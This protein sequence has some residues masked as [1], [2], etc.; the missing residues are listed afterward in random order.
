MSSKI[1]LWAVISVIAATV[2][3]HAL[4]TTVYRSVFESAQDPTTVVVRSS[5]DKIRA[6]VLWP[7]LRQY[8]TA[9]GD[10]LEKSG[11]ERIM[12]TGTLDRVDQQRIAVTAILE[13]PDRLQL[14]T[15]S[16]AQARTISYDGQ[17]A[18]VSDS[19]FTSAD[20]DLIES[21]VSDSAEHFFKAQAQGAPTRHL[22]DRFRADDGS[23]QNYAGPYHD[24]FSLFDRV[25]I[26]SISRSQTKLYYF[27]SDTHLLEKVTYQIS[28]NGQTVDV[29]N[30]FSDWQ[31]AQDQQVFRR[32]VRLENGQQ[33]MSLTMTSASVGARLND[34][35]F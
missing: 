17:A 16:G 1:P 12:F 31:K 13:F 32:L 26:G 21:L 20:Q 18:R 9:L 19:A 25:M 7:K 33:V 10:R 8:F 3:T 6:G 28:R 11:K 4:V 24:V 23:T 14:T 34:G 30:Y 5:P 35:L 22:G 15:L 2:I 27:N 29:E